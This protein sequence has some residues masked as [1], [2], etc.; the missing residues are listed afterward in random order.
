MLRIHISKNVPKATYSL[1][2]FA[3]LWINYKLKIMF[4]KS[5]LD[6]IGNLFTHWEI[7]ASIAVY[8]LLFMGYLIGFGAVMSKSANNGNTQIVGCLT[9]MIAK[10]VVQGILVAFMVIA[11][12]PILCGGD[13][14]IPFSF[15]VDKWWS[16]LKVGLVSMFIVTILS[17]I[18]FLGNIITDTLGAPIFVQGI[19]IFRIISNKISTEVLGKLTPAKFPGFWVM[20]GFM[21]LS[22]ILIYIISFVF[23]LLLTQLKIVSEDAMESDSKKIII[24]GFIEVLAGVL[25]LCIY[26][27]YILLTNA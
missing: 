4:W 2:F 27:S 5:I 23:F 18:P 12:S 16:I 11:I 19:I 7:W 21:I 1:C 22:T 25:C 13:D 3:E 15:I 9:H 10:P 14:F 20:I 6:G 24:G 8:L 17:F 26:C